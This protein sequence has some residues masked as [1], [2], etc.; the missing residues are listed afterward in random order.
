M[1]SC[2]SCGAEIF[3]VE[4][5]DTGKRMPI[6]SHPIERRVVLSQD[7]KRGAVRSVG[8]SHFETCPHAGQH[9]KREG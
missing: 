3:W 9:R 8:V 7:G 6:D 1:A 4:M 2:R 5:V